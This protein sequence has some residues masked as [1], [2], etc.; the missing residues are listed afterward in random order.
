MSWFIATP[1]WLVKLLICLL[2][3][4]QYPETSFGEDHRRGTNP[5]TLVQECSRCHHRHVTREVRWI[6]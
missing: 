6:H 2:F 3:G 4:H 1:I 5:T